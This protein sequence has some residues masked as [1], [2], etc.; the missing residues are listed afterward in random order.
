MKVD[1]LVAEIGSTTTV[2]NAFIGLYTE[3]PIFLGQGQAPTTV[4]E[5][6]VT[7]GVNGAI[8]NLKVNLGVSDLTW[9]EM[10]ATSS[11]AGGLK[12]SVHGLVYDMTVKAAREAALGAGGVIREVTAGRMR[13]RHLKK[14]LEI[15]PNIILLAGGVDYGEEDTIIHNAE[16]LAELDWDAPIIYAGNVAIQDEVQEILEDAGKRVI[17]VDNVY[18]GIDEF[19]ILPTR[20]V[21]QQ[22]F[23][24][25][26]VHAPGMGK[27]RDLIDGPMMPTPGAVMECAQL[28]YEHIGDLVA[29]DVGGATTDV[30]SVTEGSTEIRDI[31]ISPEPKAK[32]TVEGDLGVF[33]NAINLIEMLGKEEIK[34]E[35]EIDLDPILENRKPI[36]Q[37]EKEMELIG[38]LTREAV[39]IAVDRHVGMLKDLYGP[40]G[41]VKIAEGKDLT[42]IQWIIG[43]GGALTRLA[44][45]PNI[46]ANLRRDRGKKLMPSMNAQV[47]ID[48]DYIMASMGV[49]SKR[50]PEAALRLMKKSMNYNL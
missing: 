9:E 2:V 20:K 26:I 49:M 27:I 14:I 34:Q 23:E 45:G 37:T 5:G 48:Q 22:V 43:T 16:L 44:V 38:I 1:V 39:N 31:L 41:R 8:E 7:I 50:F 30:H 40:T 24:E 3:D 35:L 33:V 28:L 21:I 46:L 18:P 11:A 32:R 15:Q 12:M 17:I 25:H 4:L 6:D 29:V 19:N 10:H 36:P 47:L 13:K 42:R